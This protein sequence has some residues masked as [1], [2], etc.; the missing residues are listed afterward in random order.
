MASP[1]H[2]VGLASVEVEAAGVDGFR[3]QE[4]VAGWVHGRLLPELEAVLDGLPSTEGRV[5]LDRIELVI[6]AGG[7]AGWED[8]AVSGLRASL[9]ES[10]RRKLTDVGGVEAI[11]L[12]E[13]EAVARGL[14][15]YLEHGALP[16]NWRIADLAD[17]GSRLDDWLAGIRAGGAIAPVASRL[18]PALATATARRRFL[19][20]PEGLPERILHVL[21]G[22]HPDRLRR[23]ER[24]LDRLET[25]RA[26]TDS[27]APAPGIRRRD[28]LD[29]LLEML[30][31]RPDATE[32]DQERSVAL[33]LVRAFAQEAMMAAGSIP[34]VSEEEFES[35][36][37]R[38]AI[39]LAR[40]A[41]TMPG[42]SDRFVGSSARESR[43]PGDSGDGHP[44]GQN[45]SDRVGKR[46]GS[47]DPRD[48]ARIASEGFHVV[49]A[50]LVLVGPYLPML[51]ERVGIALEPASGDSP[52]SEDFAKA[53]ALLHFLATG[54]D[55]PAEFELVLPKVLCGRSPE[56]SFAGP[57]ALDPEVREEADQLL[58]S[59]LSHW[60]ALKDSSIDALRE[61][62]LARE[63]KLSLR[64]GIWRLQ[65]EQK[66]WDMLLDQLPWSFQ[67]TKFPWMEHPLKTEWME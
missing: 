32:S 5:V 4:E 56:V 24:D 59:V 2:L 21:F 22:V 41:P 10:L 53:V 42:S 28:F 25:R 7:S 23:W 11:S 66:A 58:A 54:R 39:A 40:S 60:G 19:S 29:E 52:P 49:H 17:L 65:V 64:D 30:S 51:F 12:S 15:H 55:D 3:L 14:A 50:G 8:R 1:G 6:E 45:P 61:G 36:A 46:E 38:S 9:M 35:F 67:Y 26:P 62:F 16:W 20:L 37:F 44:S 43:E 18:A 27:I 13:A 47:R 48:A 57:V 63:G 31:S 33:V 34:P